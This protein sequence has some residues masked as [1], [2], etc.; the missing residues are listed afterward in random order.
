MSNK[1]NFSFNDFDIVV[2]R[3]F[4]GVCVNGLLDFII[5]T[6]E[7]WTDFP[8]GMNPV[9]KVDKV[10]LYSMN[11]TLVNDLFYEI[12]KSIDVLVVEFGKGLGNGM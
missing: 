11:V 9:N 10:E 7:L 5:V 4:L 2:Y 8:Y 3:I 12:D 1:C 6:N